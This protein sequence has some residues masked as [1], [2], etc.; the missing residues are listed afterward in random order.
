MARFP[1]RKT[2]AS[3]ALAFQPSVD[4]KTLQELAPGRGIAPGD[5]VGCWGPPGTGKTPLAIALGLQAVQPRDRPLVT[6]AM[7]RSAAPT[8]ASA[9]NR[10]EARRQHDRRP[11][12][13][14]SD[15]I[16]DRPIDQHG[17]PRF[18]PRIS[19]RAERGASVLPANQGFGPGGEV[20]GTRAW[21]PRSASVCDIPAW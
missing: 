8:N 11:K 16:G 20:F 10:L 5:H 14:S 13:L 15:A 21:P 7:S 2:L 1:S 17:A 4:R 6:A 18:C 12:L 19:R 3:F 9:E